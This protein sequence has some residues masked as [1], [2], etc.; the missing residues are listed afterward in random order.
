[1]A[2]QTHSELQELVAAYAIDALEGDEVESVEDH[3]ANCPKCR[4]ELQDHRDT[5]GYL[6]YMGADAPVGLWDQIAGQLEAEPPADAKLFPFVAPA[7]R[8]K[9]K[10]WRTTAMSA[11]A[12][13]AALVVVNG[14]LLVRQSQRID[15]LEP[16]SISALA[17]RLAADSSS[18]VVPLRSQDGAL[19]ADAVLRPNGTAYLVHTN[20]PALSK[21][22]TYQLWA[23]KFGQDPVSLSVLGA[24]PKVIGFSAKHEIDQLA[25][26]I[27]PFG[28]S[29]TPSMAPLLSAAVA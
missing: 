13:A 25:I 20:L 23:I 7:E 2:R 15:N 12:V 29:K 5:A 18:K 24:S 21:N 14:A 6:S 22:Q 11:A 3:L 17:E 1:M 16:R 9:I 10:R 27:E 26:T 4:A 8:K 28:G 19:T